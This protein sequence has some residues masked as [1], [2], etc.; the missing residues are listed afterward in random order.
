LNAGWNGRVEKAAATK[1]CICMQ[2]I[3]IPLDTFFTKAPYSI[4]EVITGSS[5]VGNYFKLVLKITSIAKGF[6]KIVR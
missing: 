1:C 5:D 2:L 4:P 6:N 3:Y